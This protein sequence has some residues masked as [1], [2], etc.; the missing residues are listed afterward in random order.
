MVR[1][2]DR[3]GKWPDQSCVGTSC[4]EGNA[5]LQFAHHQTNGDPRLRLSAYG[6]SAK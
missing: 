4:R 1:R 2:G 5:P 3:G 6:T